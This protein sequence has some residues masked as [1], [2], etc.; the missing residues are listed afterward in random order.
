MH[1]A[2]SLGKGFCVCLSEHGDICYQDCPA[3]GQVYA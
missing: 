1:V 3:V 2:A